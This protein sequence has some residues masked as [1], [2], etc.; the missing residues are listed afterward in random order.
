MG[1]KASKGDKFECEI[2][3]DELS[4][5]GPLSW[6]V[7]PCEWYYE[8]YKDCTCM[9]TLDFFLNSNSNLITFFLHFGFYQQLGAEFINILS[10][11][12]K[13]IAVVGVMIT[14]IVPNFEKPK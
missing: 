14:T 3:M 13:K 6:M 10:W 5:Y 8:E 1:N 11:E 12:R 4:E 2:N 7:R 9:Y